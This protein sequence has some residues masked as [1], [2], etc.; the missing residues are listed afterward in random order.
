[1]ENTKGLVPINKFVVNEK[2]CNDKI[3]G[4]NH[5]Y[6]NFPCAIFYLLQ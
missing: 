1:M 5:G 4:E 6:N 2:Y 3:L